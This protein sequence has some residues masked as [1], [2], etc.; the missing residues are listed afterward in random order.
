MGVCDY[1]NAFDSG[2]KVLANDVGYFIVA[3]GAMAP[4]SQTEWKEHCKSFEAYNKP[5]VI[6]E[7]SP[8]Y[9]QD[10]SSFTR[11]IATASTNQDLT[12]FCNSFRERLTKPA[13]G[14]IDILKGY[15]SHWH[16]RDK[17]QQA[18]QK[19]V[20]EPAPRTLFCHWGMQE[21]WSYC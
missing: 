3:L 20:D 10:L 11:R 7:G 5:D 2:R 12:D 13:E 16:L 4:T 8:A 9:L 15:A 6:K 19:D 21:P 14:W 18:Y 17:Q 1:C